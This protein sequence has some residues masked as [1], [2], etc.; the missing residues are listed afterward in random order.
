MAAFSSRKYFFKH[1]K[2]YTSEQRHI[3]AYM[4]DYMYGFRQHFG[5][6][7]YDFVQLLALPISRRVKTVVYYTDRIKITFGMSV[8]LTKFCT[9]E[10]HI[11]F[12]YTLYI[13]VSLDLWF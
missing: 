12:R 2:Q 7:Y 3:S 5:T 10:N 9:A 13:Y 1:I 6:V 8:C 4:S 11:R